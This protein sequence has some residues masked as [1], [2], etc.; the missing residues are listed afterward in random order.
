MVDNS[1][2]YTY[3]ID[4]GLCGT[5]SSEVNV[6]VYELPNAGENGILELCESD[7]A[8]DLM[9]Y[10]NG[11]PDS[12]G[13]W[14]PSLSS[15]SG[16]FNPSA[17]MPGTY[18]YTVESEFCGSSTAEVNVI[19]N[20]SPNSGED[21]I[22]EICINSGSVDLFDSLNGSPDSGGTWSPIL[23]SG[24][25]IFNPLVDNSG[26]YTYTIDNG[27]CGTNSSEVE[28]IVTQVTPI[29]NY[30]III[31]ELSSNNSIEILINS[32]LDYQFSLDGLNYQNNN[33]FN[34]LIG[35]DY[36]VYVR[37]ING[38]GILE[39][40]VTIIDYPKYFTPNGDNNNDFWG[41]RGNTDRLYSVFIY[42][43]Y[44]KLLKS[45]TQNGGVWDGKYN[46]QDMPTNDYWFE[47]VFQDGYTKVGHFTLKR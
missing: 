36:T 7:S 24:S 46:G 5:S 13:I 21:G 12:G 33:V 22:L 25:G 42:D 44:G 6:S 32:N 40:L 10:L 28:V 18:I 20:D 37:E 2:T 19:V 16:I 8:V 9:N 17:D 35:G 4:N 30:D 1:G 3:T 23:S 14:S 27:L 11:I 34:N 38:C 39:E 43:R 41:L 26:T 47:I 29:T 45:I 15:G 31:V